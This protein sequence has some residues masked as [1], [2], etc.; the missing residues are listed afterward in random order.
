MKAPDE[1]AANGELI[2]HLAS[3]PQ[4][5]PNPILEVDREGKIVYCNP[6]ASRLQEGCDPEEEACR[7]YLP[8]DMDWILSELGAT[9]EVSSLYRE[10]AVGGT[11]FGMTVL[12]VPQLGKVRIYA[13]DITERKRAE[14]A[15]RENELKATALINVADESIWLFGLQGEILAANETAARR[16]GLRVDDVVGKRWPDLLPPDL[17][18]SRAERVSELLRTGRP[19]R[20]VDERAGTIFD[21]SAYPVRDVN[22]TITALAF[23]SRDITHLRQAEEE[24]E[25]LMAELERRAVELDAMFKVFP[26]PVSVHGLDGRYLRANTATVKLFGFDPTSFPREEV[27]GRLNARFPDGRPITGENMPSNRTLK[28]EAVSGVEYLITDVQGMEHVLLMSA[29]PL[30][31]DGHVYGAVFA[32]VDITERKRAEGELQKARNDLELRVRERTEDLAATVETLLGEIADRERAEKSL[33]RL[34]SLCTVLSETNQAIVRARDRDELFRDFCRIAVEHGGFLLAWVGLVDEGTGQL[35]MVASSGVTGYLDDIRITINEES[36][37]L[38]P[39]GISVREGSYYICNDFQHEP[40]TLPWHERGKAYGIHASASVA[41]KEEG[42]VIGALT[43]YAGEEEF[44]DKQ[45]VELLVQM[46]ADV[47][48]AL[49]NLVREARRQRAEQSLREETFE[50]LRAVEALREKE[51]MLLQQSRL[52]AMGE[53]I[54]NI[55]HQW[56]QPLNLLGL[57]VQQLQMDYELGSF[58]EEVLN[59]SVVKSMGLINHMSQTI[60]DFR[61]FFKLDKE[62]VPFSIHEVVER[63]VALVEDSFENQHISIDFHAKANPI[64]IGFP[65]EYS[66]ALLNILMNARDVLLERRPDDATVTVVI[67]TEGERSVVTIADN[68][69]GIAEEIMGKIFEPY[70]TTK[71]PDRGT[72]VGLFMSKTIIEKNMNGMLTVRNT[73]EGA[74]FRV[75]V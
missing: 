66:Q 61:N 30:E 24:R 48:F 22:G 43:L 10:S 33:Q 52:A 72:G 70:F 5:N 39:T 58:S 1:R 25:R 63:T 3:F 37:G 27:A 9:T 47:S 36:A 21:H 6:A 71:G 57:L 14:A 23:F 15:L 45:H 18:S 2:R 29:T 60:D 20:F 12:L 42:R 51:R 31:L 16:M 41:L 62:P 13:Y 74:E 8:Q 54:N 49:D 44:F 65:N 35:G 34:N 7:L 64:V 4:L 73:A 53:M 46:G 69:G 40:C 56:R 59:T 28:G 75:E 55:A 50:R 19:V 67:G 38:G 26:F 17:A 11:S 68:A 32:Q